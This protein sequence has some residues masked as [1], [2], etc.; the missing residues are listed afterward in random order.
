MLSV[1]GDDRLKAAVLALKAA[2]RDLRRTINA[3]TKDVIGPV[4]TSAVEAEASST[5]D[6]AVVVKG[7]RLKPGNPPSAV[8]ASSV[9]RLRGGLLPADQWHAVEFGSDR[10]RVTT[11]QRRG[12]KGAAHTVR[13]HTTRQL[14][15]RTAGGRVAM[16]AFK[17]VAPRAVSLWVQIIVR[18]YAV[19]AQ[20]GR[21]V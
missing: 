17:A 4:W 11:Y 8:A 6:R 21:R 16:P 15:A 14:P 13:R 10:N 20:E 12:R 3:A 9:K 2:D 18:K 19:A 7:V 1:T 5:L